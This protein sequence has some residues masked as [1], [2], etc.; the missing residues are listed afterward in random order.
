MVEMAGGGDT[1]ADFSLISD[2]LRFP[3]MSVNTTDYGSSHHIASDQPR[4]VL[5]HP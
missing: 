2:N 4:N 1:A 5:G 3:Q